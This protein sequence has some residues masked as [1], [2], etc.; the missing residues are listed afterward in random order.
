M[1]Q[2]VIVFTEDRQFL[3]RVVY[4]LEPVKGHYVHCHVESLLEL[5]VILNKI[6]G[7]YAV[8]DGN[9][10]TV[11]DP[12]FL[13]HWERFRN[14]VL[15]TCLVVMNNDIAISNYLFR[16]IQGLMESAHLENT[17]PKA[18]IKFT[19]KQCFIDKNILFR[20]T[21]EQRESVHSTPIN[22]LLTEREKQVLQLILKEKSNTVIAE[23]LFISI[24][25]VNS[26]RKNIF[27][28]LGVKS[29]VGLL[30]LVGSN[31]N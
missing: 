16:G 3:N 17:L 18:L 21:M 28:K 12:D 6:D 15:G 22:A 29:I 10:K 7:I 14:R 11:N 9:A 2:P 19:E 31:L 24:H 30:Q 20:L 25:T 23:E 1:D 27:R 26:H 5:E 13:T 4:I 8:I